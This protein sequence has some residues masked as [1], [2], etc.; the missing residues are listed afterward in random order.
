MRPENV[1]DLIDCDR[2]KLAKFNALTASGMSTEDIEEKYPEVFRAWKQYWNDLEAL[3]D[4]FSIEELTEE[5]Y[6]ERDPEFENYEDASP[7]PEWE[8]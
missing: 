6:D 4:E 1:L 2:E 5:P 3:G 7:E 8:D